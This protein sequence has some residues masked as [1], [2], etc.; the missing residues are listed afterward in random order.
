[1]RISDWSSDVC[2][3]DLDVLRPDQE[4]LQADCR[5]HAFVLDDADH[6]IAPRELVD[7]R[8][9]VGLMRVEAQ[10]VGADIARRI[11][12]A[13][14]ARALGTAAIGPGR[15]VPVDPRGLDL[16]PTYRRQAPNRTPS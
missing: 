15:R 7:E 13:G 16:H 14:L 9:E 10:A 12:R 4:R 1:M 3:S 2:S 6:A 8:I 11:R 5:Q